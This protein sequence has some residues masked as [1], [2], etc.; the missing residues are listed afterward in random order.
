MMRLSGVSLLAGAFLLCVG[1][2]AS[3]SFKICNKTSAR[4]GVAIGLDESKDAT[5]P[6][7]FSQGW[8]NIKPDTCEIILANELG[9]GPYFLHAIDYDRG[10][11]W[12]GTTLMCVSDRDFDIAGVADCYARGFSRAGFRRIETNGQKQW[13][14]DLTDGNRGVLGETE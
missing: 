10:G 2:G 11:E 6:T 9:A 1:H 8:F 12:G 4:I 14:I 3:A 7:V 13:N 5:K